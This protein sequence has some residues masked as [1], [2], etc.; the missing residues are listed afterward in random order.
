MLKTHS[1][2]ASCTSAGGSC[3]SRCCRAAADMPNPYRD[4]MQRAP[5]QTLGSGEAALAGDLIRAW[6]SL[7]ESWKLHRKLRTTLYQ[8]LLMSLHG[9]TCLLF[10]CLS[11]EG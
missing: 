5:M 4:P 8:L 9:H 2:S 1:P 7:R 3:S 11:P 6:K 10:S